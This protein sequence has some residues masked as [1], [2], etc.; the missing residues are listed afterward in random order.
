MRCWHVDF[1][2]TEVKAKKSLHFTITNHD[3][4]SVLKFKFI[5]P[6]LDAKTT[7]TCVPSFGHIGP[8]R[9]KTIHASIVAKKPISVERLCF[10]CK[11]VRINYVSQ[12]EVDVQ[13]R[14]VYL[15]E[16][17]LLVRRL[18]ILL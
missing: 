8:G 4:N 15:R 18:W 14:V 2:G 13:V 16:E 5:M 3:A 12:G 7:L 1:G 11:T 9:T 17:S 6:A 10:S